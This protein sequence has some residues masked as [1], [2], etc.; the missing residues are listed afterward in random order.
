MDSDLLKLAG[1]IV[2]LLGA[3]VA[4][5]TVLT[6][7]SV[8]KRKALRSSGLDVPASELDAIRARLEASEALETRVAELEERVDF[9]ERLL[10]QHN[11]SERLPSGRAID[12][13]H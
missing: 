1:V 9:A 4:A 5:Y 2:I 7:I 11:E 10:A 8:F 6:V 13:P 12:S 3:G